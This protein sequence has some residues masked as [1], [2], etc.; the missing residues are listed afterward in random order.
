MQRAV[1]VARRR[2]VEL[3]GPFDVG[4]RPQ[5]ERSGIRQRRDGPGR[6][7]LTTLDHELGIGDPHL[8]VVTEEGGAEP[9]QGPAQ[10][11]FPVGPLPRRRHDEEGQAVQSQAGLDQ[12]RWRG[13][14]ATAV[15]QPSLGRPG[16]PIG[17]PTEP[18][19]P[20]QVALGDGIVGE[21]QRIIDR[22]G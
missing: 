6:G 3:R 17:M 4:R 21:E 5:D 11:E 18:S 15:D 16:L 13:P 7:R 22:R 14:E 12:A 20:V 2:H 1:D 8:L 19:L 10:P 9:A